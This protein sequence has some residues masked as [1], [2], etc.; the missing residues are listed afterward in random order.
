MIKEHWYKFEMNIM[1]MKI[2]KHL[3]DN[4]TKVFPYLKYV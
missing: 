3:K 1:S 4:L 2:Q